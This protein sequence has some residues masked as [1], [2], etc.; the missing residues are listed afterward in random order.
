MGAVMAA[1]LAEIGIIAVR[2]LTGPKRIPL[3]S[4]LLATFVVFGGLGLVSESETARGPAATTAWG[5]VIATLLSARVGFLK[6]VGDFLAG[7]AGTSGSAAVPGL[8]QQF[9]AGL[10]PPSSGP[11]P[12]TPGP[13]PAGL[14]GA[15]GDVGNILNQGVG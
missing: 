5:L 3:P 7:T 1:W 11:V 9:A 15:T 8:N 2:D 14:Q 4:E 10:L 6:P 12:T 13:L